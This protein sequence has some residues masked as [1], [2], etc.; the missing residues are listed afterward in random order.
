MPTGQGLLEPE[1]MPPVAPATRNRVSAH[2]VLTSMSECYRITVSGADSA[3]V[4]RAVGEIGSF[5]LVASSHDQSTIQGTVLDQSAL[6][7]V[8]H[9][10]QTLRVELLEVVRVDDER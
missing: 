1:R 6:H 10:L 3:I 2:R 4:R 8:L 9:R 5:E 7:G